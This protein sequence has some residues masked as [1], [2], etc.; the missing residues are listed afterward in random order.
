MSK[1]FLTVK[2]A[3]QN[4]LKNVDVSF[5]LGAFVCVTGVSGSGKSS[6]VNL[7]PRFY[8]VTSGRLL[9]DGV[10]IQQYPRQ[11]LR[12]HIG[13]VEQE[14]FL[15]SRTIGEN[16]AYGAGRKVAKYRT[17][18]QP[19]EHRHRDDRGRQEYQYVG[20]VLGFRHI[21]AL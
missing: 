15:F 1:H 10:D 11:Y 4:N 9:I 14:P 13:I 16:I 19:L 8:E 20:K 5:P 17:Q 12:Q 3:F 2:G 7:L 6:L 21:S 18:T